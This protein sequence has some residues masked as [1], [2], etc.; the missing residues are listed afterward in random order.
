M[1]A[2][3]QSRVIFLASRR[4][5][6]MRIIAATI[7]F[8]ASGLAVASVSNWMPI[9]I[10][11]G[12]PI[13]PIT[14]NGEPARAMLD[15]GASGNSVSQFFLD[16]HE[17]EYSKG[18][19]VIVTSTNDQRRTAMINNMRLGIF[20]TEFEIDQLVPAYYDDF[21]FI[22]GRP[23]F[24]LFVVQ[25]DYPGRRMR[26]MDH[27]SIDMKKFA[28]VK[29]RRDGDFGPPQVRVEMNGEVK[30]WLVLDTGNAGRLMYGCAN[31]DRRGWL[32]K[33]AV[34]RGLATGANNV[35]AQVDLFRLPTFTIGPFEMEDVLVGVSAGGDFSI[36]RTRRDSRTTG[37]RL[38]KGGNKKTD[39]I[40]G[41]DVL[42]HYVVTMDLKRN[43][44]NLDVPR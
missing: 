3:S 29:M 7:L 28:N 30:A 10:E 27:A 1:A 43:R 37:F 14:L 6:T 32:E 39:G 36:E 16:A 17:G 15:T 5:T 31:A 9:E 12:L 23:F 13:I 25:I 11:N 42:Q 19:G 35:S 40:L 26:I 24:E 8:F 33:Y 2:R 44:L 4:G 20:G 21:D 18:Q 34:T 22:I 41:F 38:K